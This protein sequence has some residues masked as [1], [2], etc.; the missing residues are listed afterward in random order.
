MLSRF[1]DFRYKEVINVHTGQR[2]GYVCD[3]EFTSPEGRI[4]ALIVPG[5][6]RYL[7]LFGRE[8][9]YIL[10]GKEAEKAQHISKKDLKCAPRSAIIFALAYYAR[11][12]THGPVPR[13]W[14]Q[15]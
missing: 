13:G 3:A 14:P 2:L 1:S 11:M 10:P 15:G 7:G 9:D 4:T 5:R 6:A 12:L 8:E